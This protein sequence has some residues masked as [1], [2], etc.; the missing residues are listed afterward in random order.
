[1][2][3]PVDE[4]HRISFFAFPKAA[5]GTPGTSHLPSNGTT[6]A[7]P[8]LG[9]EFCLECTTASNLQEAKDKDERQGWRV[10]YAFSL[11]EAYADE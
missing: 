2:K 7:L 10:I 3:G 11:S 5:I 1:M 9:Q 4:Y 6:V 8:R